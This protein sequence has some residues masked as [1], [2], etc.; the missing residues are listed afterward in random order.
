MEVL[1]TV[2]G[3]TGISTLLTV[4]IIL[5]ERFFNNYGTC[6]IDIND[7]AKV[8]E[9]E[10][11]ASLLSTLSNQKIFIPSACGGK[12]T[13]GMCKL[14]VLEGAD[15]LLPTEEP[16]L[17]QDER[18]QDVR[19][20]CQVKIKRN[21]RIRIP[22][23]LFLVQEYKT[24]VARITQKT[25][26]IKEFRFALDKP[27]SFKAGQYMQVTTKPYG[28]VTETV[29]RAYSISSNPSDNEAVELIVRR[30]PQGICTTFM[31]DHVKE[32]D[33]I[34]LTGPYGDF[35]PRAEAKGYIMIAGG[36]GLAPMRAIVLDALERGIDKEMWFFFGA[37]TKKDL[38]YVDFFRELADK[39]P[40]FHYIPALSGPLPEDNWDGQTG[41]I[42]DVVARNIG[43]AD[44]LHGLLCG[45]PGMI[46]ACINVLK[47][48]GLT[49]DRIFYDKF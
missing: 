49:D 10:G 21:L 6:Q 30:V 48:K 43:E 18:A 35:Y 15:P 17:S 24:K 4:L 5:A 40:H 11:G 29:W 37:V 45:S 2:A 16:Y 27:I 41:L 7:G 12:A 42:T 1:V 26:D 23:E 39:H 25:H 33:E 31:H 38:Y 9:V 44:G 47:G 13:C 36:S 8:L 14:R 3:V 32:G 20:S 22:D 46:N 34:M 19:L 28:K